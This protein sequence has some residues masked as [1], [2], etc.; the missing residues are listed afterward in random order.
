MCFSLWPSLFVSADGNNAAAAAIATT[1]ASSSA[2]SWASAA[3]EPSP[4]WR[5]MNTSQ[6]LLC[7][8]DVTP[9]CDD[10]QLPMHLAGCFKRLQAIQQRPSQSDI[11]IGLVYS[12]ALECGFCTIETTTPTTT[13]PPPPSV[14]WWSSFNARFVRHFAASLPADAGYDYDNDCYTMRLSLRGL[15]ERECLLHGR[16][17]GVGMLLVSLNARDL[18]VAGAAL[19]MPIAEFV[20]RPQLLRTAGATKC[21]KNV[22]RLAERLRDGL[23]GPVR[24][25]LLADED[26]PWA[27]L[28]GVPDTVREHVYGMLAMRDLQACAALCRQTRVEVL[29]L[30]RVRKVTGEL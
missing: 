27:G 12:I 22:A 15:C 28:L 30:A 19:C 8:A 4:S 17:L 21:V 29:E 7:V 25:A 13:E 20:V 11:L 3:S 6:A 9:E 1:S 5:W 26:R 16:Q 14:T 10:E 2:T 18:G 24:G 23:F